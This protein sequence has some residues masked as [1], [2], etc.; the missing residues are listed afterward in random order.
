MRSAIVAAILLSSSMAFAQSAA[1]IATAR[2][3]FR[4]GME[5]RTAGHLSE[6]L[7]KLN[8]RRCDHGYQVEPSKGGN[9]LLS[10][11]V[12]ASNVTRCA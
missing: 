10:V 12:V 9:G 3:L 1:D 5:L 11:S 8:S 6:A 2:D 4:E 7:S